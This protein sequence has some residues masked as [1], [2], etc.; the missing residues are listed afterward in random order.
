MIFTRL[1]ISALAASVF[2]GVVLFLGLLS[3]VGTTPSD[4]KMLFNFAFYSSLISMVIISVLGSPAI[5][6]LKKINKLNWLYVVGYSFVAGFGLM[7]CLLNV[8]RSVMYFTSTFN[9]FFCVLVGLFSMVTGSIFYKT[10]LL[11]EK[12]S[13][14]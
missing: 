14:K 7:Y 8:G 12:K 1:L 11:L 3:S 13:N 2:V 6:L 9:V 5:F 4:L 10:L